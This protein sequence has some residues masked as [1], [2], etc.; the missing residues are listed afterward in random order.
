MFAWQRTLILVSVCSLFISGCATMKLEKASKGGDLATVK[1]MLEAHKGGFDQAELNTCL[2]LAASTVTLKELPSNK[3]GYIIV[4]DPKVILWHTTR[5][6]ARR[7]LCELLILKGANV[8]VTTYAYDLIDM[9]YNGWTPLHFAA[10][11]GYKNVA[12][13]LI[14]KGADINAKTSDG[15]TPLYIATKS[16]FYL[17]DWIYLV[18]IEDVLELLVMKG[19]NVNEKGGT[20]GDTPLHFIAKYAKID[21]TG[22]QKIVELLLA[23]GAQI[24]EKNKHGWTPLWTAIHYKN[25]NVAAYLRK[26]GGTE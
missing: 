19:A 12:D 17:S 18:W 25:E 13:L 14:A 6:L 22:M 21:T 4:D 20:N 3:D 26:H 23:H 7:D 9:G 15:M 16:L 2:I 10:D 5:D 8:N 1:D 11:K 24:N